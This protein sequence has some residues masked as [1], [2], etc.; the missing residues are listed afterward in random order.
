MSTV[1]DALQ[2]ALAREHAAV[3]GY[4]VAGARLAGGDRTTASAYLAAHK[5]ARDLLETL[6]RAK[7]AT[8]V[9]PQPAYELPVAVTSA[10]SARSLAIRIEQSTAGG[11]AQLV[12]AST[13]TVRREAALAMQACAG[14]QARWSRTIDALPGLRT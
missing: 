5:E 2:A 11:Y 7:G 12:G 1:V 13:G 14:R 3:Y 6:V 9:G 8:P 10:L 4:G